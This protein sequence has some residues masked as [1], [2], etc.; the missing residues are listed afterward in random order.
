MIYKTIDIDEFVQA[1]DDYGRGYDFS[2]EAREALFYWLTN[3]AEETDTK[4][5]L[6]V[7]ALCVEWTEYIS[8][9]D[10]MFDYSHLI[11]SPDELEDYTSHI[12]LGDDRH[13]VMDY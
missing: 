10:L 8:D 6:D 2:V 3:Y 5:E 4:I 11:D 9:E 12:R 7:I 1:F 13:L